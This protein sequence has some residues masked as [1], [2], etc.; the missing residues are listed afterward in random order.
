MRKTMI[1]LVLLFWPGA[2]FAQRSPSGAGKIPSLPTPPAVD[3]PMLAP[4]PP[5]KRVLSSWREA[6][7]DLR[8]RST[9]L[10]IA[11]DRILQAEAQTRTALAQYLPTI[12][13]TGTYTRQLLTRTGSALAPTQVSGG[14]VTS[15]TAPIPNLL[16]GTVQAQQTIINLSALDQISINEL[17]EDANKLSAYDTRRTL[18]LGLANQ[19][20]SVVTAE[21]SAE[22]N[23]VGLK[24]ALELVELVKPKLDLGAATALDVVLAEQ[25]AEHARDTLVTGDESLREAREALGLALGSP[26]ETGVVQDI[27][28][29]GLAQEASVSCRPV[30]SI[31]E[32]PDVAAARTN[33]E[34]AKRNLRNVWY[35]FVPTVTAQSTL[36]ESSVIPIGYP[37]PT[38]NVEGVL[39]IPIWDGGA[40]YGSLRS[41]RAAED[42]AAQGLEAIRRQAAIEVEQAQRQLVVAQM[43]DKVA[44]TERDLAAR[45][46]QLTQLAYIA[47]QGTSLELVTASEAHREAELS[48]A[49]RDYGVIKARLLATLAL[50]TCTQ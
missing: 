37:N 29:D 36:T 26:Q 12:G 3:D 45:S 17:N 40:R 24:K 28:V 5:P 21:R 47:G 10:K 20:V 18:L 48:L 30:D 22:V 19:I 9:D 25:N 42:I 7:D 15:H 46:D 16:I 41:A 2:A 34:V 44:R 23:R 49:V 38:W 32:R 14:Y 8:A 31:D 6:V 35:T 50:V 1:A 11:L 43:S 13:A 27:N 33:L 39:S 4:V